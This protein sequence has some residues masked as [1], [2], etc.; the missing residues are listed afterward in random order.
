MADPLG[1][2][3]DTS[4]YTHLWRAGH[5]HLLANLAQAQRILVPDE[6]RGEIEQ[7][8]QRYSGIPAVSTVPW[9]QQVVLTDAEVLTALSVKAAMGGGPDEHMGECAVIAVAY[10]RGSIALIDEREAITQAERLGVTCRDTLWVVISE[11]KRSGDRPAAEQAVDALLATDMR[12]PVDDGKGLF[13]RA[14]REGLL[15]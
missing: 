5:G 6:V 10:H 7:G 13:A 4:V 15:P 11:F 1:W 3:I 12:L 8:R 9:A 2:V 14:Y